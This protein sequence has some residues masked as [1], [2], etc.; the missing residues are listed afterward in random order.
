MTQVIE[1]FVFDTMDQPVL[2]VE[3]QAFQKISP[4]NLFWNPKLDLVPTR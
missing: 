2:N 1:G 4:L 3:V